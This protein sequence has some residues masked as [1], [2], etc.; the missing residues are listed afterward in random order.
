MEW[1]SNCPLISSLLIA[2][3]GIHTYNNA[4][5]EDETK[6]GEGQHSGFVFIIYDHNN[7][8]NNSNNEKKKNKER[9]KERKKERRRR[10]NK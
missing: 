7:S 10:R 3:A 8:H 5:R 6:D 1:P 2:I 9:K 4:E